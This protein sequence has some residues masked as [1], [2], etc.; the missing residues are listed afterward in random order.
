MQSTVTSP[1]RTID[2]IQAGDARGKV[3]SF[4]TLDRNRLTQLVGWRARDAL[5]LLV[6]EHRLATS[7]FD[8]QTE[9]VPYQEFNGR[10]DRIYSN[11]MSGHWAFREAITVA[12]V[13]KLPGSGPVDTSHKT[14]RENIPTDHSSDPSRRPS[15]A[16]IPSIKN[17]EP[18]YR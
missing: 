8:G 16:A 18:F 3:T 17:S 14:E 2:S 5:A 10:D 13:R 6:L 4:P 11:L 15:R 12:I 1:Y 9:Y 7:D